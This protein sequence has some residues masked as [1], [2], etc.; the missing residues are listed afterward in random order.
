M[1]LM[2]HDEDLNNETPDPDPDIQLNE[3]FDLYTYLAEAYLD[4]GEQVTYIN[5]TKSLMHSYEELHT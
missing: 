5:S 3:T 1:E 4:I 2:D